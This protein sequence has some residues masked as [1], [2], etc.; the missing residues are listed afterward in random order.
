MAVQNDDLLFLAGGR[1]RCRRCSA[2]SKRA[3]LAELYELEMLG[4]E[5][6]LISGSIV[7]RKPPSR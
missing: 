6:G 3:K 2:R 1:I 5:L 7:G 4:R